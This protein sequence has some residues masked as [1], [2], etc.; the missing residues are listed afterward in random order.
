MSGRDIFNSH[1]VFQVEQGPFSEEFEIT[2][3]SK[4]KGIFD[5]CYKEGPQDKGNVV[6][7]KLEARILC[8]SVPIGMIP[9]VTNITRESGET[10]IFSYAGIDDEGI[11]Y[12]WLI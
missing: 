12:L 11:S 7:R 5:R 1:K 2:G 3:G 8:A 10:Y 4:F 6:N 9:R